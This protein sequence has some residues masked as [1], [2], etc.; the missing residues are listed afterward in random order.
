MMNYVDK[1]MEIDCDTPERDE[2]WYWNHF[3]GSNETKEKKN[4][5]GPIVAMSGSAKSLSDDQ[6]EKLVARDEILKGLLKVSVG[7]K[8]TKVV[9][10]YFFHDALIDQDKDDKTGLD[11]EDQNAQPIDQGDA[12]N[13]VEPSDQAGA[14]KPKVGSEVQSPQRLPQDTTRS[15]QSDR[16]KLTTIPPQQTN[17]AKEQQ[18]LVVNSNKKRP[19]PQSSGSS[20]PKRVRRK[21]DFKSLWSGFD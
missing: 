19:R 3:G 18:L 13:G 9:S 8:S 21:I 1:S 7:K 4:T 10:R 14:K 2:L 20:K 12:T 11:L 17:K 16:N 15:E 6:K 5:S